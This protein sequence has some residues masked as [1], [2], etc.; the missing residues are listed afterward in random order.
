MTLGSLR[1]YCFIAAF[2]FSALAMSPPSMEAAETPAANPE[3]VEL[4]FV[5]SA[6]GAVLDH[7]QG[8]LTLKALSPTTIYFSDRPYRLAGHY[9]TAEFL[10]LWGE[11]SDSFL[12]DPPNATLSVFD[13][14]MADPR[15]V[16]VELRDVRQNGADLVYDVR[17]LQ[18]ELPPTDGPASL[19]IDVIGMPLTPMSYAGVARRWTRRAILY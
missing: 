1:N 9:T 6:G 14:T 7:E 16:V 3:A 15:E 4:L 11:G 18:G 10:Q 12:A 13:P 17:I 19:F 8:T 2:V 5:Q